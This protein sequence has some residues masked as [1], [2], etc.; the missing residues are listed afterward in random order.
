[1]K[2]QIICT[3]TKET[4]I[5][6]IKEY[7]K[8]LN[9]EHWRNLRTKIAYQRNFTC[10][11]CNKK[12]ISKYHIHH[13]TYDNIG[14]EKDEDLMFLCENC[15]NKI[16]NCKIEKRKVRKE[17][18]EKNKRLSI[19]KNYINSSNY[20]SKNQLSKIKYLCNCL[21]NKKMFS[22]KDRENIINYLENIITNID[23]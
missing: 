6:N 20:R 2:K 21:N 7:D 3:D 12:V 22:D 16:H 17:Q 14:N 10:E 23:I 15:H 13:L 11:K 8:Y 5:S 4:F 1:M 18:Q 9:S 19:P